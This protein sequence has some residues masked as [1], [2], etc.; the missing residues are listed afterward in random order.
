VND[1][2]WRNLSAMLGLA[3]VVLIIAAGALLA[4]S[5]ESPAPSQAAGSVASVIPSG[6][7][8]SGSSGSSGSPAPSASTSGSSI[9]TAAPTG[10]PA[11]NAPIAHIT[12]NNLQLDGSTDPLGKPRTFTFITDGSGPI[13]IAITKAP[14]KATT[15]ICA[16]VDGSKPDC[17]TGTKVTYTGAYTDTAHSVWVVTLIGPAATGPTVDVAFSWPSNNAQITLT[18]GRF[19]GSS[20]PGVSQNLNGFA[21]TFTPVAAGNLTVAASWTAI[22]TNV[23]V[24]TNQISGTSSNMV[25]QKQI[26]SV[27]NLGT[28]GY[29]FAVAAGTTYQVALRNLSADSQRP[30]LTAVI[31][32]P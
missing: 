13:G 3:C 25:D 8:P 15:R 29:T 32:I 2:T 5:G 16:Q 17:R 1:T 6:S 12:F 30:D 9:P 14:T 28:P 31:S 18:H 11:A 21:A 24:T 23:A 7:A 10:T 19:Q 20:S 27:T 4:T 26:N 22:T